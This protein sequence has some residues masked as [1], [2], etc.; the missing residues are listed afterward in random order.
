MLADYRSAPIS[1]KLRATLGLLEKM[2]LAPDSLGA[3]DIR[4]VLALG[5]SKD[6][7]RDA[8]HVAYLF[9]IYDRLAD[10]M[11]WHVPDEDSGYYQVAAKRLLG[12]GYA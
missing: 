8:F 2:T 6:A 11:G 10:T 9:N 5:V 4:P 1:E 7:L 12:H 3:E